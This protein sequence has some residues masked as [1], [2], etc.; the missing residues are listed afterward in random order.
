M[1]VMKVLKR[2]PSTV[3]NED[4]EEMLH[5]YHKQVFLLV[6][7]YKGETKCLVVLKQ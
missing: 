5:L 2:N 3:P 7:K 4:Q 6:A 1:K